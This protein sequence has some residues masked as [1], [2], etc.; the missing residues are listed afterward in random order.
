MMTQPDSQTDR[1]RFTGVSLYNHAEGHLSFWHPPEWRLQELDTPHLA[2]ALHPNPTIV[3]TNVTIEVKDLQAPLAPEERILVAEGIKAGLN[4]LE[5]L[6]IETWHALGPE[7][8]GEWGLEWICYFS[9]AGQRRKRRARVFVSHHYL[10][11]VICQ[12]ATEADYAYWQGMFEFVML[13]VGSKPF[14]L[15]DWGDRQA[16][17]EWVE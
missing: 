15:S 13:T 3:A 8:M 16:G 14:S 6:V 5:D 4:E 7:T 2:I 12:G 11:S 1:P 9:D 17:R 10:Y